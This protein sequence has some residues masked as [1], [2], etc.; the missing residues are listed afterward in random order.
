MSNTTAYSFQTVF[1]VS[2]V[3]SVL[4]YTFLMVLSTSLLFNDP[5]FEEDFRKWF[6]YGGMAGFFSIGF[7]TDILGKGKHLYTCIMILQ[8]VAMLLLAINIIFR[9]ASGGN[10]FIGG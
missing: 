1:S 5:L 6:L 2:E 7:Y 4:N 9:L 10:L 8:G 3:R